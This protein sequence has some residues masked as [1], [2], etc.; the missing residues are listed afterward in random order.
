MTLLNSHFLKMLS[1][2]ALFIYFVCLPSML[3]RIL[4]L[5]NLSCFV[6]YFMVHNSLYPWP[7]QK[8]VGFNLVKNSSTFSDAWGTLHYMDSIHLFFTLPKVVI[9][10]NVGHFNQISL[11]SVLFHCV[12]TF[13]WHLWCSVIHYFQ[14]LFLRIQNTLSCKTPGMWAESCFNSRCSRYM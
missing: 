13:H 2:S 3:A 14:F 6:H 10:L 9:T 5:V 12:Q 11:R 8:S 1:K 7:L 4:S